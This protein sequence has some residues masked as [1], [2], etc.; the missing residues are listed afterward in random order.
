MG[1]PHGWIFM[2]A[3]GSFRLPEADRA[4]Y[5]YFPLVNEA[6][7]YAS[8]TPTLGGD[9]KADHNAFL[10]PPVSVEDLHTS[11]AV[12]NFWLNIEGHGAWSAAG[13]SAAQMAQRLTPANPETVTL[14]AGFLWQRVVRCNPQ[15]GLQAVAT[16]FI[17]AGEDQVE[18]M[19]VELENCGQQPLTFT[20]TAAIPLYAR[21]ADNQRDHRHVTSLLH[22]TR[23]LA[24]GV[25][26]CPTLS[27]DERGHQPNRL[28]YAVLGT[29]SEGD[30]PTGFFPTVEDFI[31]EGG[32]LDWPAAVVQSLPPTH[33][34]GG[35]VDGYEA[36]GGLRFARVTL[37][38]GERCAYILLLAIVKDENN[39]PGLLEKYGSHAQFQAWLERTQRYWQARLDTL[40]FHGADER[41]DGWLRWVTLQ[42]V[43]RRMFGNSFLPYHDYGR[44][45]RG[46]RD[47]WQD[48]LALLL[49][50][51]AQA[52]DLLYSNFAGVRLDGSNATIIGNRPGE[53]KADR[54]NIPRVW[55]D[56][57]AWPLLTVQLYLDQ[58]G[59]LDFLLRPQ[60]YFKD[61][62]AFRARQV[63]A[64]WLPEQ[65]T[66]QLTAA[67]QP[68]SGTLLEHL[69]IQHLTPFFNVG[70]HNNILLEGAD[71][72]DGMDMAR[73]R[74]E[75][76]AFS[77]LY[78]GNLAQ[79]SQLVLSLA[80][81]GVEKVEVAQEMLP[82][83]DRISV[84]LDYNDPQAKRARLETYFDSV[85]HTVCG[86]KALL[87]LE[88]LARDLQ[89]KADWLAGHIRTQEWIT[90]A[91]G[92]GWFNGYYDDDGQRVEGAHPLGARMTL[93]GQVFPLM[94]GIATPQQ[95]HSV[96]RAAKHY[97]HDPA[98]GGYRLNSDFKEVRLNLG[99]CFGFAFGHKEN[100]AMFSHMAVMYAN[101]L[102]RCS[103]PREGWQVLEEIYQQSQDFS[104]SH[105]LPGLP[106][107]FS[108]RGRGVY[109]FLTGS[110]SWYLLTLVTLAYG[111]QGRLGDLVLAPAL[112]KEQF[113]A[114]GSASVETLF[115][116]LRLDV[117]YHNP[118]GL[119]AGHYV[120]SAARLDGQLLAV[121]SGATLVIPRAQLAGLDRSLLHRLEIELS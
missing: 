90:T 35:G 25:A 117:R 57:G 78:A 115:A 34:A 40:R 27:F 80:R 38:P 50:E 100:G 119:D 62:L 26:V 46:W 99:R 7:M 49:T 51:P 47:L 33:Q 97:L 13:A 89:A 15:L 88:E 43:L 65:G 74:G 108:A 59:D 29:G 45:G 64:E 71:W 18:L 2:D 52:S 20:P 75:S 110:A 72:N 120:I 94:C 32:A 23:C 76:V 83:L 28:T 92:E 1:F 96:L 30:L 112:V 87:G 3:Q 114:Q 105:M 81:L 48:I 73:R 121:K 16:S 31:G 67:G 54:N 95:V 10:L 113:D 68:Y 24:A 37:Q 118:A 66:Q 91:E 60:V 101:A 70:E 14:E 104:R 22:R 58:S 102:Y 55:M 109:P 69:L 41:R 9:L 19:R 56:H 98:V 85:R 11:R 103:L 63:D 6:G 116:G 12:R 21:S 79:I 53:F 86:H 42:P 106:E 84:S 8:I 107:Y 44:G 61:R 4:S 111:V 77:A 82:L 93:T 5:L 39:L 36:L 17:P